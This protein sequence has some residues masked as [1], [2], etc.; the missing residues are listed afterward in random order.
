MNKITNQIVDILCGIIL[1]FD[2]AC[3]FYCY[4]LGIVSGPMYLEP[5]AAI[6][7]ALS[8]IGFKAL[9]HLDPSF[10]R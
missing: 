9:T 1:G 4:H 6:L 7:A 10:N 5:V 2:L 3:C 8:A